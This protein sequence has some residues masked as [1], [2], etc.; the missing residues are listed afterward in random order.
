MELIFQRKKDNNMNNNKRTFPLI[1]FSQLVNSLGFFML[2]FTLSLYVLAITGSGET[3]ATMLALSFLPRIVGSPLGGVI[4]D[5]F[6]K[7][8]L[9][10]IYD[11]ISV[12]IVAGI[13]LLYMFDSLNIITI[14]VSILIFSL[15]STLYDPVVQSSIPSIVEEDRLAQGNGIIS[16]IFAISDVVSSVIAGILFVTVGIQNLLIIA[17]CCF[18]ASLIVDFL[19]KLPYEKQKSSGK[20]FTVLKDDLKTGFTH[21][22]KK[23]PVLF[24]ISLFVAILGAVLVSTF[25]VGL[26][27]I[28]STTL[29]MNE[30][31]FGYAKAAVA[32]SMLVGSLSAGVLKKYISLDKIPKLTAFIAIALVPVLIA[33]LPP[34]VNQSVYLSYF[35][36]TGGF[37]MMAFLQALAQVT[38]ITTIQEKSPLMLLGKVMAMF[39]AIIGIF[40]PIGTFIIGYLLDL[41]V[42]RLYLLFISIILVI[43]FIAALTKKGRLLEE[44]T[45]TT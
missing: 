9:L 8:I 26:P 25:L 31:Y 30:A 18:V 14:G 38:I 1:V 19:L 20:M 3:F 27:F 5:R 34:V 12:F 29:N 33:V 22:V 15:F 16:G 11:S 21:M 39:S 4:A 40:A 7:K 41:S 44:N 42:N 45:V 17:T 32:L 35:L 37:M 6:S 2:T 13:T 28:I 23:D 24:K 10:I 43:L 36:L